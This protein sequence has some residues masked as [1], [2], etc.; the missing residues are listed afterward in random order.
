MEWHDKKDKKQD[1]KTKPV[2][3]K[4]PKRMVTSDLAS[5]T[6]YIPELWTKMTPAEVNAYVN[7]E[8]KM[9]DSDCIGDT[10]I[11]PHDYETTQAELTPMTSG[12]FSSSILKTTTVETEEDVNDD[13][14][15]LPPKSDSS[16]DTLTARTSDM[17]MEF[18]DED[19]V[20]MILEPSTLEEASLYLERLNQMKKDSSSSTNSSRA[21]SVCEGVKLLQKIVN[22]QQQNID[23]TCSSPMDTCRMQS[24]SRTESD[25][26]DNE[27]GLLCAT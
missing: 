17:E 25:S 27:R 22:K 23:R 18:E 9:F 13:H 19:E 6:G 14:V 26:S 3:R 5:I 12:E 1:E 16:E 24:S 10:D 20:G 15:G 8:P 2:R 7:E 21:S 4:H 11:I